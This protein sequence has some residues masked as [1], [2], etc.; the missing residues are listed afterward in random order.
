MDLLDA[1]PQ[2]LRELFGREPTRFE[3]EFAIFLIRKGRRYDV[4][5]ILRGDRADAADAIGGVFDVADL[6]VE[7][8]AE[9]TTMQQDAV[10]NELRRLLWRIAGREVR[11][12]WAEAARA[13]LHE[14]SPDL[15]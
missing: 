2:T 14:D 1:S 7:H 6:V 4:M 15:V 11:G 3:E 12:T 8:W 10:R 9:L 5:R 13:I